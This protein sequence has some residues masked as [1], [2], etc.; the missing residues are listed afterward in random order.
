[1]PHNKKTVEALAYARAILKGVGGGIHNLF[2]TVAHPIDNVIYPMSL[3]AHDATILLAPLFDDPEVELLR[4]YLKSHPSVY[5]DASSRMQQRVEKYKTICKSFMD[6]DG[7]KR[8]EMLSE[9]ATGVFAPG[10]ML[11]GAKTL[12]VAVKNHQQF[13]SFSKP[14][15]FGPL[16]DDIHVSK[17]PEMKYVTPDDIKKS[18]YKNDYLY[19]ITED[20]ELLIVSQKLEH[21]IEI[22]GIVYFHASHVETAQFKRV[23]AAGE[24]TTKNGQIVKIDNLSGHYRPSGE[25]LA[26]VVEHVFKKN[27]FED[28]AGKFV[29]R[30]FKTTTLDWIEPDIKL[31]PSPSLKPDRHVSIISTFNKLASEQIKARE[32]NSASSSETKS[33]I[34]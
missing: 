1:M 26:S 32:K 34:R 6:G 16:S 23:Y 30:D 15:T 14:P 12:T 18:A 7:P 19:A 9:F 29:L 4:G 8:T 17:T 10:F 3:L 25:N 13:G 28:A 20:Q 5:H 31:A 24:L 22:H 2:E 33:I 11:K 27:G 21:P